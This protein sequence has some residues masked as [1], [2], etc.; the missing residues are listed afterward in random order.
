MTNFTIGSVH[1]GFILRRKEHVADISSE[2]YLFEHELLGTPALAI[3]NSDPNKTFCFAFQTI[4]QDSTGVAHILE[5][6]VLMGS[7]KYPVHDV[8]GEIHKGGLM[9]FLNAMTGADVTWY[10]FATRNLAEY[11]SIMDVY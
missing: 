1:H 10:P 2:V 9:T 4:P 3:K 7:K 5:H 11:F 8:F 6:A